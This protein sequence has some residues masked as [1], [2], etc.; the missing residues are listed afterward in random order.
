MFEAEENA[1]FQSKM[2]GHRTRPSGSQPRRAGVLLGAAIAK[3]ACTVANAPKDS[4]Q[5]ISVSQ[6]VP[7]DLVLGCVAVSV[8]FTFTMVDFIHF[9]Q[10]AKSYFLEYQGTDG[11]GNGG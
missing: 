5:V 7:D 2:S 11:S 8:L 9:L 3:A 6:A 1:G 4:L 10:I